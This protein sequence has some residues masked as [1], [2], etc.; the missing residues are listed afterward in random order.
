M[1]EVCPCG[2]GKNYRECCGRLHAGD[3]VAQTAEEL[4]RSRYS[5]F[6]KRQRQYLLDTWHATTRPTELLLSDTPRWTGLIIV[7]T[8]EGRIGDTEGLVEFVAS[9]VADGKQQGLHE[10]S[11]FVKESGRWLYV[12]GEMHPDKPVKLSRNAPCPCGSGKKYK[13]CCGMND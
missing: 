10:T 11:R 8:E 9:C 3:A 6:V 5:A 13:K 12:D 7:R 2:S 4:M 1:S